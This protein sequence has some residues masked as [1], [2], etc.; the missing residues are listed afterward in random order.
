[1]EVQWQLFELNIKDEI[2]RLRPEF[3]IYEKNLSS[4]PDETIQE[5]DATDLKTTYGIRNH[6]H[7]AEIWAII[8]RIRVENRAI[9]SK[10][11][12]KIK[13]EYQL[14]MNIYLH[15]KTPMDLENECANAECK[16]SEYIMNTATSNY[17]IDRIPCEPIQ[18]LLVLLRAFQEYLEEDSLWDKVTANNIFVID[19]PPRYRHQQI[20][21]DMTHFIRYHAY[22]VP[23]GAE[24]RTKTVKQYFC[25]KL[26]TLRPPLRCVQAE[27]N[28][29]M[30]SNKSMEIDM[31]IDGDPPSDP[32]ANTPKITRSPSSKSL[33]PQSACLAFL[34]HHRDREAK[35]EQALYFRQLHKLDMGSRAKQ[36]VDNKDV[37]FQQELDRIHSYF[38]QLCAHD[39]CSY[40]LIICFCNL[41]IIHCF[42]CFLLLNL[43]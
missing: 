43:W 41:Y 11:L 2:I 39:M 4:L 14:R 23:I 13:R 15:D 34:R 12:R 24:N 36:I 31:D 20:H 18:R 16:G 22:S 29:A 3:R 33:L 10:Q 38:L 28:E 40:L 27:M 32:P 37:A 42:L 6:K 35:K 9:Q 19:G 30:H 7:R 8:N 21:D 25:E 26:F 5:L 1:M 17:R